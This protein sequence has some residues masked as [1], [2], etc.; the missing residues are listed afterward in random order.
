MVMVVVLVG[1]MITAVMVVTI[2]LTSGGGQAPL[3]QSSAGGVPM[4]H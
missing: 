2:R 4:R 1:V 3:V